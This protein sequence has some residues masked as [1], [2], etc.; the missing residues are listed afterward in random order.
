[1]VTERKS[2]SKKKMKKKI[3]EKRKIERG[4]NCSPPESKTLPAS[5]DEQMYKL[6]QEFIESVEYQGKIGDWRE[7]LKDEK[8]PDE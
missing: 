6:M 4:C 1:M 8:D 3:P 2:G 7:V 5:T